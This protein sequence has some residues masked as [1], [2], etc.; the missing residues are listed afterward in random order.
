MS[1][2]SIPLVFGELG[3][4]LGLGEPIV[5]VV[6]DSTEPSRLAIMV[7]VKFEV[8]C[9]SMEP[10]FSITSG[11]LSFAIS[12]LTSSMPKRI[13]TGVALTVSLPIGNNSPFS[14]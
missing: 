13:G 5:F 3:R 2:K 11:A 8:C 12:L 7:V 6:A 14:V 1:S 10:L 9:C 4:E